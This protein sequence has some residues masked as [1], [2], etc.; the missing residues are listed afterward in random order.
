[1]TR[2]TAWLVAVLQLSVLARPGPAAHAAAPDSAGTKEP[3]ALERTRAEAKALLPVAESDLGRAFLQATD[4]LPPV[5][6]ERTL[7]VRR[8]PRAA[9]T[10]ER[11]EAL[12]DSARAGFEATQAGERA[13]RSSFATLSAAAPSKTARSHFRGFAGVRPVRPGHRRVRA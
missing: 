1:M 7:Y 6:G 2:R 10:P 13:T 9:I 3:T 12:D 8:R 5:E 4:V 11:Y